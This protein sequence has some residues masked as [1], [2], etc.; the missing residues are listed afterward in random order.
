M[1]FYNCVL[2]G[3]ATETPSPHELNSY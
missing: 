3:P 1:E 2:A